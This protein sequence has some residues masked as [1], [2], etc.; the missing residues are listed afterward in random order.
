[1][2]H[3]KSRIVISLVS[4][5]KDSCDLSLDFKSIFMKRV[6]NGYCLRFLFVTAL[7]VNVRTRSVLI[8]DRLF[9]EQWRWLCIQGQI[10]R[11]FTSH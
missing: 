9:L 6:Y 1:M 8:G 5:S 10:T 7:G 11:T 3:P 2:T 4:F